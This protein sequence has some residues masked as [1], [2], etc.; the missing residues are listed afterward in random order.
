MLSSG[1]DNT[2]RKLGEMYK[3]YKQLA[4]DTERVEL[5]LKKEAWLEFDNQSHRVD[6]LQAAPELLN[7][8]Q[9]QV[10]QRLQSIEEKI[11]KLGAARPGTSMEQVIDPI[12]QV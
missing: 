7:E 10:E 6:S 1:V 8:Q 5:L 2:E 12:Y 4:L 9:F 11:A 3:G